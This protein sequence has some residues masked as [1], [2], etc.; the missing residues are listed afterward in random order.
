MITFKPN[1]QTSI[2]YDNFKT[3]YQNL[4]QYDNIQRKIIKIYSGLKGVDKNEF[5]FQNFD[6]SSSLMIQIS[7]SRFFSQ[8][9]LHYLII[10]VRIV[11]VQQS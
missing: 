7:E 9:P 3:N 4:I 1:Y 11:F 10:R 5:P 2:R 6:F 8:H